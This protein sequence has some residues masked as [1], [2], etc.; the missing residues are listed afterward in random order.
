MAEPLRRVGRNDCKTPLMSD[1]AVIGTGYVGLT[2]GACLADLGHRVVC[3]DRDIDKI[4]GLS[5]GEVSMVEDGLGDLVARGLR[6]GLL[7][8]S[9]DLASA[10]AEVEAVLLSLPTPTATDGSTDLAVLE[11]VCVELGSLLASGTTVVVRSTVPVGTA[12]RL[13]ELLGRSDLPVVANPEFLREGTAVSD[14]LGPDRIV[15]GSDDQEAAT[16]VASFYEALDVPKVVT[17]P[18]AA[19]MIKYASNAYLVTRLSFINSIAAVCEGLDADIDAVVEGLGL[20]HRVGSAYLRPGPGWGGS[21]FPKDTRSLVDSARRGGY[22]FRFLEAAIIANEEQFDRVTAKVAAT[23]GGVLSG[24]CVAVWGVTFKAGTDDYRDSPAVAVIERMMVAGAR[25][26]AYDPTVASRSEA[27]PAGLE[28]CSDPVATCRDADGLV[29]LTE[30]PEFAEVDPE[31]VADVLRVSSIV[32]TRGVL[33]R[34]RW[35][36]AGFDVETIG[37]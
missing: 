27:L 1:L 6:S 13:P 26:R 32:D 12:R 2:A 36:A 23:I 34:E 21:C 7:S 30:W 25:V 19:E 24:Q 4:A 29:V 9:A 15:V 35:A 11:E 3:V 31:V 33:D 17:D 8:F 16:F 28:I 5:A 10:V 37:R 18:S 22:E 20:D 14:F